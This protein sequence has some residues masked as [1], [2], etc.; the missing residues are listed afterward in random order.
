SAGLDVTVVMPVTAPLAKANAARGYGA[1]VVLHGKS[2]EEA[3]GEA[4]AIAEREGRRYVRPF[5]DESVIAGQGTLGLEVLEQAP[6][7]TEILVPAGGGGL[8]AGVAVA[9]K[10]TNPRGRVGS[11]AT[12]ATGRS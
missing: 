2:L 4:L 3:R 8:L 6:E 11:G 12:E 5:D 7:A 10:E 1:R 9:V